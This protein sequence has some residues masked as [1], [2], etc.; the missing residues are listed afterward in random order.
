VGGQRCH[1]LTGDRCLMPQLGSSPVS[2]LPGSG[3]YTVAEY[4]EIVAHAAQRHIIVIPEFD[5][6]GHS[7]AAVNAMEV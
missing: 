1:D 7:H 3:F 6:P 4:K 2:S 5:M